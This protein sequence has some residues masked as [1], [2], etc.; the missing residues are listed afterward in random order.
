MLK[1]PD[2]PILHAKEVYSPTI[3]EEN[4]IF[5]TPQARSPLQ[6]QIYKLQE[7]PYLT[8][9]QMALDQALDR[10][11]T[12]HNRVRHLVMICC[13]EQL[14]YPI[15]LIIV[16][17]VNLL[18]YL[19][20]YEYVGIGHWTEL[21]LLQPIAV[22]LPLLPI[23]FPTLWIVLSCFGMARFKALFEL[24]QSSKKVPVSAYYHYSNSARLLIYYIFQLI[25]IMNSI[26]SFF[27]ILYIVCRSF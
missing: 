22:T 15:L 19:Y 10:P 13:I 24:Y 27:F 8:N 26:F 3:H 23:I 20:F 7:T 6:N 25:S 17:L 5:S 4:E 9:L 11:V 2:G 12:Y 14:V 16:Q 1:N 21:F 18:R